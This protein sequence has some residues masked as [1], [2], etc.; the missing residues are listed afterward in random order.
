MDYNTIIVNKENL[1]FDKIT[2]YINF[3]ITNSHSKTS[4]KYHSYLRDYAE[5]SALLAMYTNY[6]GNYDINEIMSLIANEE[7][8]RIKNELG[9]RYEVF[10]KY[11]NDEIQIVTAPFAKLD[12]LIDITI[13]MLQKV[14]DAL[15]IVDWEKLKD[16]DLD[17]V[18]KALKDYQHVLDSKAAKTVDA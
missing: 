11:V 10:H 14:N 13:S 12:E 18:E 17:E 2:G 3:V 15:G 7:W 9:E 4:G 6:N 8:N 16:M 5:A 1:P